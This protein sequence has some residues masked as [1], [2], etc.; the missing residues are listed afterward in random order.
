MVF[1]FN[2]DH[3]SKVDVLFDSTWA[4]NVAQRIWRPKVNKELA[5]QL[6]RAVEKVKEAG[7]LLVWHHVKAHKGHTM[8]E[9]ADEAANKGAQK[10]A[11][12]RVRVEL[13]RPLPPPRRRRPAE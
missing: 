2:F 3:P 9:L 4:A 11:P 12:C 13:P 7:H 6:Q 10:S 8:N 1:I 5:G